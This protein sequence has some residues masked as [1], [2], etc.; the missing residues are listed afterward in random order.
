MIRSQTRPTFQIGISMNNSNRLILNTII[1]TIKTKEKYIIKY[2]FNEKSL[3]LTLLNSS[4]NN[5]NNNIIIK[6]EIEIHCCVSGAAAS[7]CL[8]NTLLIIV[9]LS[10]ILK[11]VFV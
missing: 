6:I 1:H 3:L 2:K 4:Y 9:L 11:I 8:V 7:L 10:L 5:K